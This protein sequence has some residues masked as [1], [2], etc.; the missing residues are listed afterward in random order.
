M[1]HNSVILGYPN[2]QEF[3]ELMGCQQ[4]PGFGTSQNYFVKQE[5]NLETW[6]LN[7]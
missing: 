1:G 6:I 4:D 3:R 7:H 5:N 2:P